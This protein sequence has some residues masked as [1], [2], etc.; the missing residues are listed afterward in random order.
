MKGDVAPL[1]LV[2]QVGLTIALSI[3]G[4]LLIGLWIDNNLG[5]R[6]WATLVLTLGGIGLGSYAVYRMLS[7]A[8]EIATKNRKSKEG[9]ETN[10]DD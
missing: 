5:T 2:T 6:P 9:Q 4:G 1:A 8:I 10:G 7:E 3:V